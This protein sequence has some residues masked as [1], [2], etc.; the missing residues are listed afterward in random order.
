MRDKLSEVRMKNVLALN[1]QEYRKPSQ[2]H[3]FAIPILE[4]AA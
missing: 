1:H 4:H 3:G 2:V